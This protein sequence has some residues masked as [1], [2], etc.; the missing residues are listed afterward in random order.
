[1]E[2]ATSISP[3]FV[4]I[5][6]I[7]L[8]G[9]GGAMA[10]LRRRRVAPSPREPRPMASVPESKPPLP[11]G[12]DPELMALINGGQLIHAIKLVRRQRPELGLKEAK[13]YVEAVAAGR[14]AALPEKPPPEELAPLDTVELLRLVDQGKAIAAIKLVRERTGLGL[15]EAKDYVER[16]SSDRTMPP[17]STRPALQTGDLDTEI[18]R[19]LEE[20]NPIAAIKLVRERTGLGLKE[21]KEYVERL[22]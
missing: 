6:V 20:R 19:L 4:L 16:L 13:D 7:A 17:P 9:I 8:E 3:I 2:G 14:Q 15:K 5:A 12:D 1:M 22:M 21:A 11:G 18:Q 10:L